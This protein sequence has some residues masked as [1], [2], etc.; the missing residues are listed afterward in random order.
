MAELGA[1]SLRIEE[2]GGTQVLTKLKQIDNAARVTA[3][4]A[5]PLSTYFK[6]AEAG[7]HRHG[8]AMSKAQLA[9]AALN[10]EIAEGTRL[11]AVQ[12]RTVDLTSDVAIAELRA[13]AA[14]QREWLVAIGASTEQQQRFN[15]ATMVLDSRL[16]RAGMQM[17]HTTSRTRVTGSAIAALAI[18]SS[19]GG[20]SLREMANSAGL[21]ASVMALE[22]APLKW[23]G[24]AAGIGAV[25]IGLTAL[26]GILARVRAEE[27]KP[28]ALATQRIADIKQLQIA[29][30]EYAKRRKASEAA[31]EADLKMRQ[32]L[33][34][35]G[36]QSP[37]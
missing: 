32:R 6:Q 9:Q 33:S 2:N 20:G 19:V 35:G 16:S 30:E 7:A 21:L 28:S 26:V 10:K 18:A 27:A 37:T 31:A 5:T 36:I 17:Q 11:F 4:S 14:A 3:Q 24:Y 12:A 22:F 13:S 8:A 23:Q 1:L 25:V 34:L 29:E 15:A